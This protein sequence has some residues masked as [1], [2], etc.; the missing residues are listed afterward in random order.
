MYTAII[1]L[2]AIECNIDGEPKAITAYSRALHLVALT[3]K[4]F[5]S[6][7]R[8]LQMCTLQHNDVGNVN[9]TQ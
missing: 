7:F 4:I 5:A 2:L 3:S 8:S 1:H 6:C 9:T